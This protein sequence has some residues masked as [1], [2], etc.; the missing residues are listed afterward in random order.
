[1]AP[2]LLTPLDLPYTVLK[3]RAGSGMYDRLGSI[4]QCPPPTQTTLLDMAIAAN[5]VISAVRKECTG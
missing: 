1:M 5:N 3:K 2:F 4:T